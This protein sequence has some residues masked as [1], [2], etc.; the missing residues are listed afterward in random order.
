MSVLAN[1]LIK[2]NF[3]GREQFIWW[4]GQI[5]KSVDTA[6]NSNRV[7]VRICGYH[8]NR[9]DV[10]SDDLPWAQIMT[11]ATM[12]QA[13][14]QGIKS[15]L[16]P[17]QWVIGFFL[18][19][20][21]AQ[22]PIVQGCLGA[23]SKTDNFAAV[24]G[25]TF[26]APENLYSKPNW[27]SPRTIAKEVSQTTVDPTNDQPHHSVFP[28]GTFEQV[29]SE[30]VKAEEL[31]TNESASKGAVAQ[32]QEETYEVAEADGVCS[33][34]A[35]KDHMLVQMS[36]F[37]ASMENAQQIGEKWINTQTGAVI[38]MTSK[39]QNYSQQMSNIMQSPMT[40]V[41]RLLQDE[42][43]K[44]FPD[45][46]QAVTTANPFELEALKEKNSGI[47]G[48]LKCAF[49]D[50]IL[51]KLQGMFKNIMN[52]ML[53]NLSKVINNADCLL[54]AITDKLFG[55][56]LDKISGIMGKIQGLMKGIGGALG[57]I[58]GIMGK[59]GGFLKKV[60]GIASCVNPELNKCV[61]SK[62][63]N[64]K[65]GK[66]RPKPLFPD[67]KTNP[68][69]DAKL[70]K[71]AGGPLPICDDATTD[72]TNSMDVIASAFGIG[73]T[74]MDGMDQVG[75]KLCGFLP[76]EVIIAYN[77]DTLDIEAA[78]RASGL[79]D[80]VEIDATM[81]TLATN[82][83]LSATDPKAAYDATKVLGDIGLLTQFNSVSG[84][85]PEYNISGK[86]KE[87][88]PLDKKHKVTGLDD[89]FVAG[90]W[91][92]TCGNP[93]YFF[94][95]AGS[96][97][98]KPKANGKG[99]GAWVELPIDENGYPHK[100][101]IVYDGGKDYGNGSNG[102]CAP[103]AFVATP[104]YDPETDLEV[105][106]HYLK[107]TA[108]VDEK[109]S[110][111]AVSFAN[112]EGYIFKETP[113]VNIT[114]CGGDVGDPSSN[115]AVKDPNTLTNQTDTT[116]IISTS[117]KGIVGVVQQFAIQNVGQGYANPVIT[118]EG[119]GGSGATAECISTY[120][121]IT[122]IKITNSGTGYTS[123]P[124]IFIKDEPIAGNPVELYKGTSAKAYA[125]IRYMSATDPDLVKKIEGQESIMSIDCP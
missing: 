55:G 107:G 99:G 93:D 78:L 31:S 117:N 77:D 74:D 16:V 96:S 19:G 21:D 116:L 36:E 61:R 56:I 34:E 82:M 5:E 47:L 18:D 28:T 44:K 32:S 85:G 9:T 72:K 124:R 14:G 100:D 7:K 41:S 23:V 91:V 37:V 10:P 40:A 67:L 120:G 22:I 25:K 123:M 24:A 104:M 30:E 38:N 8:S 64:T 125:I 84:T 121:R 65:S 110:I 2:P 109:G 52:G 69:L 46:Y 13:S 118:I 45:I 95:V 70:Q 114:P 1:S 12:S 103:D 54:S 102:N 119:G 94:Q 57:N 90:S 83:G 58:T 3:I 51:S 81:M 6:K 76:S 115:E 59:V 50:G 27:G 88:F 108:F 106:D 63:F 80:Q 43:Q 15:M 33:T 101:G 42:V 75:E 53:K 60:L 92:R 97:A 98:Y 111:T 49:E 113:T 11:P 35:T 71:L 17:G 4:I 48:V 105:Q 26:S 86:L 89:P 122:D 112:D 68:N 29:E 87:Y 20:E 39:I 79:E 62:L 73:I 66:Q